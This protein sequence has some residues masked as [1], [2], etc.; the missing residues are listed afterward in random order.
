MNSPKAITDKADYSTYKD[1][2]ENHLVSNSVI[3]Q[4]KIM[5]LLYIRHGVRDFEII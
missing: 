5:D 3:E 2:F 1:L 4:T